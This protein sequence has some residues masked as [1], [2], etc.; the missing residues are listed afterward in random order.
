MPFKV[1]GNKVMH[2]KN[3]KWSIKQ[4]CSS[5]ANAVKAVGLLHMK[6]YGSQESRYSK[7]LKG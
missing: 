4:R 1:I 3:G 7:G 6:G 5:H 2:Y